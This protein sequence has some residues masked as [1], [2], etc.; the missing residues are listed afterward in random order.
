MTTGVNWGMYIF[1]NIF[2]KTLIALNDVFA[3]IFNVLVFAGKQAVAPGS[4]E[5]ITGTSQ[6]KAD[7]TL[8]HEQERDTYKL[9]KSQN[10]NLVIMGVENQSIP[11]RDMPFRVIGYDGASYRSQLLKTREKQV[12]G[13]F[14]QV[15][16]KER[17]PVIT[18]VLYF[19][20]KPW[21]YPLELKAG[22]RPKLPDNEITRTMCWTRQ[23]S[24]I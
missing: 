20:E 13:E 5:D 9:W 3:D 1:F 19:G 12:N 24:R 4:L 2:K 17:S 18:I 15:P 10:V 8:V 16:A 6:Y 23:S 11:D 22:F 14:R 7:D 21:R